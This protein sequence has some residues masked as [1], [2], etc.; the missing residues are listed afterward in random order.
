MLFID[1]NHLTNNH[2][3]HLIT[4]LVNAV[5]IILSDVKISKHLYIFHMNFIILLDI[6]IYIYIYIYLYI[7]IYI[8]ISNYSYFT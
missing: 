7:Y 3:I 4:I 5:L 8:Y 2:N 6:Y 1:L